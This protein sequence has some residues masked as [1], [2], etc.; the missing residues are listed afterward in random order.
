MRNRRGSVYILILSASLLVAV[1]GISALTTARI[2]H[3]AAA[4]TDDLAEARGYAR[5]AL[6]IALQN[7]SAD[8]NWRTTYGNSNWPT[9]QPIGSG[10]YTIE[11]VDPQDG[12]VTTGNLDP[13]ELTRAQNRIKQLIFNNAAEA[14][15]YDL[16]AE[17][18]TEPEI[19]D[20][21]SAY[22]STL[23]ENSPSYHIGE[24]ALE[25]ARLR[26]V[27]DKNQT[28]PSLDL[29]AQFGFSGSGG[30]LGGSL[31]SAFSDG[32]DTYSLGASFRF[33]IMN[34]SARARDAIS[35]QRQRIAEVDLDSIKQA[36]QLEFFASFQ[37][38]QTNFQRVGSSGEQVIIKDL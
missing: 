13:I 4:G 36:I 23:L 32:D 1:I 17:F 21:F 28:L 34:R 6:E 38:M 18:Y 26:L 27:R 22:L 35:E 8:P 33:P 24:I 10:T 19:L 30:S 2:Q 12:D 3:R 11:A 20:D 5:S 31:E 9:N 37:I 7:I 14:L 25:I 29:I 15:A 16:V